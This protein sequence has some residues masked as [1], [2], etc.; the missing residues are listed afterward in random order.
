MVRELFHGFCA[1]P[2][3]FGENSRIWPLLLSVRPGCVG[4]LEHGVESGREGWRREI[5]AE[6]VIAIA[7]YLL[8]VQLFGV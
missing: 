1:G 4:S 6:A 8:K 5:F 3:L 2:S 7:A